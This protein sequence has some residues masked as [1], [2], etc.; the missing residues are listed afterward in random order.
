MAENQKKQEGEEGR[1]RGENAYGSPTET[2]LGRGGRFT[3]GGGFAPIPE[4]GVSLHPQSASPPLARRSAPSIRSDSVNAGWKG[5]RVECR[6]L[7]LLK[8]LKQ[9][10][11]VKGASCS[12]A[13]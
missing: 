12:D 13:E 9:L 10:T 11:R 3:P 5:V 7:S 4:A 2:A 1:Q 8:C 6:S